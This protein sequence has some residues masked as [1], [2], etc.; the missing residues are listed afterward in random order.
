MTKA[1][2]KAI[3]EELIQIRAKITESAFAITPDRTGIEGIL[4][5]R[6]ATKLD[7]V[8]ELLIKANDCERMEII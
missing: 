4:E 6:S 1:N 5:L 2:Q 8:I 7:D 3:I